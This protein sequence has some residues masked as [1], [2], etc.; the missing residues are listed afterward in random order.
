MYYPYI[1]N[2][3]NSGCKPTGAAFNAESDNATAI[4][5]AGCLDFYNYHKSDILKPGF[6]VPAGCNVGF[7]QSTQNGNVFMSLPPLFQLPI[8]TFHRLDVFQP[9]QKLDNFIF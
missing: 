8:E 9:V 5:F 7:T 6:I 1:S 3:I 4:P 2:S